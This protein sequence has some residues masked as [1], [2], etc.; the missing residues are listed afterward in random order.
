MNSALC[1]N[2][3][4]DLWFLDSS[5]WSS[6][7]GLQHPTRSSLGLGSQKACG[8]AMQRRSKAAWQLEFCGAC[9]NLSGRGQSPRRV[10]GYYQGQENEG[11]KKVMG[12]ILQWSLRKRK[13]LSWKDLELPH[14][15]NQAVM[16]A[17][18]VLLWRSRPEGQENPPNP[19]L[20]TGATWSLT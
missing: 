20:P 13:P 12:W 6:D 9:L 19:S 14:F 5:L 2:W 4:R 1:L 16:G 11:D 7:I 3:L 10:E 18:R 15:W 8:E 17:L